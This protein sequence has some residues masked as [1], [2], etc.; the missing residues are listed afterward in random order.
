MTA[1]SSLFIAHRL[2]LAAALRQHAFDVRAFHPMGHQDHG[3]NV[4]GDSNHGEIGKEFVHGFH[5][6]FPQNMS[7][8]VAQPVSAV[9][10]NAS[11]IT[12]IITAPAGL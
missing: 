7:H 9:A 2:F 1:S 8:W 3:A 4:D 10:I 5:G 6:V 12:Q 11:H